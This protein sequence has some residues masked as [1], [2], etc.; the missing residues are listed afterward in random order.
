MTFVGARYVEPYLRLFPI[1][2]YGPRYDFLDGYFI[3]YGWYPEKF[4]VRDVPKPPPK[5]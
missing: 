3:G 5:V 2:R 4:G 1:W